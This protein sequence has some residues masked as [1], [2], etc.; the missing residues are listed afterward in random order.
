MQK[1]SKK[2][3]RV[4][5]MMPLELFDDTLKN[6]ALRAA[7]P[8]NS[9]IPMETLPQFHGAMHKENCILTASNCRYVFM[10]FTKNVKSPVMWG[11]YGERGRGV[12]LVFDFPVPERN[13]VQYE[14]RFPTLEESVEEEYFELRRVQ[15][16]NDNSRFLVSKTSASYPSKW[17]FALLLHKPQSC[18]FEQEYRIVKT[19][20]SS[21]DC[22]I[23]GTYFHAPMNYLTGV[24]AGPLCPFSPEVLR[25]MV[26]HYKM[27]YYKKKNIEAA[28]NKFV[29]KSQRALY[30][31]ELFEFVIN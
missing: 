13:N 9:I 16:R 4:Y 6:W 10:S 18:S 5:K 31:D 3:V 30:H 28:L 1:G 20:I 7:E 14:S 25:A 15:Y 19:V 11:L 23:K 22:T 24:I 21:N 2:N 17:Q 27:D 8:Y 12:C 26:K 29:I